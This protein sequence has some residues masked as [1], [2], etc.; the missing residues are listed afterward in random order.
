VPVIEL[1]NSDVGAYGGSN[2][3]NQG[4]AWA[5]P[6]AWQGQPHS[7]ELSLPPLAVLILKPS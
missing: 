3:G 4:G 2:F 7:V 6:R 1:I 5:E